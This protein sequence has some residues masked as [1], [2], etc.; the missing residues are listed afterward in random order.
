MNMLY[1]TFSLV[2]ARYTDDF[3]I[4]Y[5]IVLSFLVFVAFITA[6]VNSRV[7]SLKLNVDDV[8]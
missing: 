4:E 2:A 3:P 6:I 1:L 7:R 8:Q 5:V